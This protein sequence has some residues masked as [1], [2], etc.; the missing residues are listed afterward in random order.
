MTDLMETQC[1]NGKEIFFYSA[2]TVIICEWLLEVRLKYFSQD[3]FSLKY[4]LFLY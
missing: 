1:K 2:V 3:V 4:L